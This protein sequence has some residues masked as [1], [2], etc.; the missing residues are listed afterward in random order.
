[1]TGEAVSRPEM[2]AMTSTDT[3]TIARSHFTLAD[4]RA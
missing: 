4:G 2:D 1:V 3:A